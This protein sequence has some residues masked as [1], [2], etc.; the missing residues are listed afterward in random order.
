M[1]GSSGFGAGIG[2]RRKR[3]RRRGVVFGAVL[4]VAGAVVPVAG[5]AS[6]VGGGGAVD[7]DR[8]DDRHRVPALD[9]G[10]SDVF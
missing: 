9:T 1:D 3:V 6:G 2:V 8:V 7:R 4:P 10:D 5:A